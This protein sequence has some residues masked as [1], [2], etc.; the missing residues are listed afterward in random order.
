MER[1]HCLVLEQCT[2]NNVYLLKYSINMLEIAHIS[3][4][5]RHCAV[6]RD[7]QYDVSQSLIVT[8][9]TDI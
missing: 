4:Q 3:R 2:E 7:A 5:V 1:R 8:V 6:C 9:L